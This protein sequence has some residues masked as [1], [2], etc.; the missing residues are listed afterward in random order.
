MSNDLTRALRTRN[1]VYK[2]LVGGRRELLGGVA[3]ITSRHHA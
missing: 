1:T 2:P 3:P